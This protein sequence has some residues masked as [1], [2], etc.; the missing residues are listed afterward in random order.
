MSYVLFVHEPDASAV[1]RAH[2]YFELKRK[3]HGIDPL[4]ALGGDVRERRR[5]IDM[6]PLSGPGAY[7]GS[8][9]AKRLIAGVLGDSPLPME[10]DV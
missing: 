8:E 3:P 7:K 9:S 5:R 6:S 1:D 2:I 10:A 4:V